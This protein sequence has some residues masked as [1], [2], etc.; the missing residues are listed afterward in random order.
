MWSNPKKPHRYPFPSAAELS[1]LIV[2]AGS[3]RL[4][5]ESAV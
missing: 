3:V 5:L 4:N 2:T 1:L